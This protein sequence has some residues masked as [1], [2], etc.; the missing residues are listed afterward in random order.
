MEAEVAGLAIPGGCTHGPRS[1]AP[2]ADAVGTPTMRAPSGKLVPL[3]P[4]LMSMAAAVERRRGGGFEGIGSSFVLGSDGGAGG[5]RGGASHSTVFDVVAVRVAVAEA[6]AV[7]LDAAAG[8]AGGAGGSVLS[9]SMGSAPCPSPRPLMSGTDG[10]GEGT[11]FRAAS[12]A[13][14][15]PTRATRS[16]GLIETKEGHTCA[17][18]KHATGGG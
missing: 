11:S 18:R 3:F 2:G 14:H 4:S 15:E 16:G 7:A 17:I 10:G 9:S 13:E 1:F 5:V 8:G 6:V 12:A